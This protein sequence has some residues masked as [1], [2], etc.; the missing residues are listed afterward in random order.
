MHDVT[1]I[2]LLGRFTSARTASA[3]C[4]P[5]PLFGTTIASVS[6]VAASPLFGAISVSGFIIIPFQRFVS[7]PVQWSISIISIISIAISGS[8]AQLLIHSVVTLLLSTVAWSTSIGR[9][10]A[11][12]GEISPFTITV[13]IVV[14][15]ITIVAIVTSTLWA[16]ASTKTTS[17]TSEWTPSIVVSV[18]VV[19]TA[20]WWPASIRS[21]MWI[22]HEWVYENCNGKYYRNIIIIYLPNI[23]SRR[24]W[25]GTRPIAISRISSLSRIRTAS[26]VARSVWWWTTR[27]LLVGAIL[28]LFLYTVLFLVD[29][30]FFLCLNTIRR[31]FIQNV[32]S[33]LGIMFEHFDVLTFRLWSRPTTRRWPTR[34]RWSTISALI[35]CLSIR[36][37]SA[38]RWNRLWALRSGSFWFRNGSAEHTDQLIYIA[39]Y[40]LSKN[41]SSLSIYYLERE[42][43]APLSL[44]VSLDIE[45]GLGLSP[46]IPISFSWIFD[47]PGLSVLFLSGEVL[48]FSGFSTAFSSLLGF[49]STLLRERLFLGDF[50]RDL[51]RESSRFR[52]R[53]L[54]RRDRD[55]ERLRRERSGEDRFWRSADR[56]PAFMTFSR[57]FDLDRRRYLKEN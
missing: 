13:E 3:V 20:L 37:A 2:F 36:R 47:R 23:S 21:G 43:L 24:S 1:S 22:N 5:F 45:R 15:K 19:P 25:S 56:P 46:A 16:L 55:D 44:R 35:S 38:F 32:H 49:L 26:S 31:Y 51:L 50:E 30:N 18:I 57:D 4:V 14:S 33:S 29:L 48:S 42:R 9:F 27:G 6:T 39:H 10:A 52:L 53:D 11:I 12:A 17:L 34:S 41:M 8:V 7:I 54:F 28:T 40:Y